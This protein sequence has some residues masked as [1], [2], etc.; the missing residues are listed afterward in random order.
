[1]GILNRTQVRPA[2][3]PSPIDQ[4][5]A[6]LDAI[7]VA[8]HVDRYE[9]LKTSIAQMEAAEAAASDRLEDV[10]AQLRQHERPDGDAIAHALVT[11][12]ELPPP[13]DNLQREKEQLVAGIGALRRQINDA[14]TALRTPW[15]HLRGEVTQALHPVVLDLRGQAQAVIES[16]ES[17]W[18]CAEAL[19][20][21][22][23]SGEVE[24]LRQIAGS[25]LVA[26]RECPRW[27][28]FQG[29]IPVDPSL[30][31]L[32]DAAPLKAM[33]ANIPQAVDAPTDSALRL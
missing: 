10:R 19:R 32:T 33:R 1:M 7:D 21:I 26:A 28:E 13:P 16:I 6:A 17:L 11:G 4:A 18:A 31:S 8:P 22:H 25:M 27:V 9:S 24:G 14:H 23:A 20:R 29:P 15:G 2:D 3:G 5:R 12:A 30:R